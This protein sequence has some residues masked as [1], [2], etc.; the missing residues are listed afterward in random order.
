MRTRPSTPVGADPENRRRLGTFDLTDHRRAWIGALVLF[1]LALTLRLWHLGSIHELIFDETYY[2]KDGWTIVHHG[3]E[4]SW[5]KDIDPAFESGD[6]NI[7]EDRGAYVVHPS[8]GKWLIGLPMLLLGADS[9]W[10]WRL[11]NAILGSLTVPLVVFA[12]RRLMRSTTVG[13]IAGLLL[14]VDGLHIVHSRTSLLDLPLTFFVLAA[15]AA[16]LVDRDRFRARLAMAATEALNTLPEDDGT[17]GHAATA[18]RIGPLQAGWRPWRLAAG[19]LLGMACSV[20]WSGLYFLAAFGIM[21]VLWDWWARHTVHERHWARRGL[22]RD[23]I[24]AFFA[25]VGSALVVYV[26]SWTGWFVSAKGYLRHWAEE[27]GH[28]TGIGI[29]D[30]LRSLWHYHVEAYTFHVGLDS[31][32]PY[33]ATP[34]SWPLMLR[35]T[36]FYYRNHPYG[37]NGC[38]V[39]K[40]SAQILAVGNPLIWWLG[41]LAVVATIALVLLRRDG[42]AWPALM[43][44]A[45]GYLPWVLL[46]SD[47]TIFTFY[48]VAFE[49]FMVLCLAYVLG[50][51]IGPPG[52]DRERR[53]AG[54]LFAAS[55]L[56]L[57]VLISAYFWP[58]WSGQVIPT[59]QWQWRIWLPTW[60]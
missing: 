44:L 12:G 60:I 26:A 45:G 9:A 58:I 42:R 14:A 24:P 35:P 37:E 43:G 50:L 39:E 49:P 51:A 3:V 18:S 32:H 29:L 40:C 28:S 57:I 21:T 36:S 20:K 4:M 53:L 46:Y 5:P 25:M 8:L 56:T 1:A 33:M 55:V 47:R 16:L 13:L 23:A 54:G 27:N 17:N 31:E 10:T 38:L 48:A 30:A 7:Y 34:L 22:V 15:F 11:A 19:V 41:T 52:A 2:V 6:V 59:E